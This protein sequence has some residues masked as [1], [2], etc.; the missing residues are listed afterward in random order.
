M[1]SEEIGLID[2]IL[3]KLKK[4]PIEAYI[5]GGFLTFVAIVMS[6]AIGAGP[7][8]ACFDTRKNNTTFVVEYKLW[9]S[10]QVFKRSGTGWMSEDGEWA[11]G[12]DHH[13]IERAIARYNSWGIWCDANNNMEETTEPLPNRK[14]RK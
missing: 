8:K 6:L 2:F 9:F 11:N 7:A 3:M 13:K 4:I 1:D 5:I 14:R 10:D 12:P